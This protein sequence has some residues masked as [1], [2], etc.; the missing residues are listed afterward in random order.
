MCL[1]ELLLHITTTKLTVMSDQ[2]PPFILNNYPLCLFTLTTASPLNNSCSTKKHQIFRVTTF[3][4]F[5]FFSACSHLHV[6]LHSLWFYVTAD[7]KI[8]DHLQYKLAQGS[9][10]F[11]YKKKCMLSICAGVCTEVLFTNPSA[12]AGYDTRSVFKRSLTGLNSE[13][14]FS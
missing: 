8:C 5:M 7:V 11:S 3:I 12:R 4:V 6:C 9:S 13:F 2:K 1:V 14:S 10:V